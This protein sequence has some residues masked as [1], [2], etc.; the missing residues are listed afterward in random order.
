M[1]TNDEPKRFT[2]YPYLSASGE[3]EVPDL[4]DPSTPADVDPKAQALRN[5]ERVELVKGQDL[6]ELYFDGGALI[7][8]TPAEMQRWLYAM[9]A[10]YRA[11]VPP[12]QMRAQPR[13]WAG[14]L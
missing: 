13:G 14:E 1:Y 5:F 4:T 12:G 2:A 9:N 8:L 10:A 3:N 7:T 11:R 6:F